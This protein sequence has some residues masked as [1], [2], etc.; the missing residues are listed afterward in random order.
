LIEKVEITS[1]D[2]RYEGY[3]MKNPRIEGEI[4]GSIS[5]KGI[6]D[7]LEG[8]DKKGIRILLNGFKRYR[9]AKK[10]GIGIVPYRSI[11]TDEA[12]GIIQLIRIS[13]AKGLS[14]LEQSSL[15]DDL[16]K[17]QGMSI[18]EISEKVGRSKSWVSVRIGIIEEMSELIRG[19]IF[20]GKFPVYSYMYTLRQFMRINRSKK[21]ECDEFVKVVS[22][23]GLSL[24]DIEQ[25]A[26]GY[27]RG[28]EVFREQIRSGNIGWCL[29]R[30]RK[31]THYPDE[32]NEHERV[33]LRDLEIM[34]RYMQRVMNR[35]KDKRF[36]SN[37]FYAQANL[38]SSGILSKMS[39]FSKA[40]RKFYDRTR[41]T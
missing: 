29:G 18:R 1:L 10:L 25:L 30:M 27:F 20:S 3:R 24:R 22:G 11:G 26:Q 17:V 32:C 28:T 13:N 21:E 19:K 7:P 2:L 39:I 15:I 34:Q 5:E 12:E 37:S 41:Q 4:L 35:S 9:S 16:K 6:C 38:L 33:M 14:I 8:V 31:V 40:L 36:K 23:K